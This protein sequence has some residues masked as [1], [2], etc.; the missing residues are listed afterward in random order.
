MSTLTPVNDYFGGTPPLVQKW[1]SSSLSWS[2]KNCSVAVQRTLH[3]ADFT[4]FILSVPFFPVG[5]FGSGVASYFIF[6][7]WLFGIN[8]V[9]TMMTAAFIVIPEVRTGGG[10]IRRA[11]RSKQGRPA[12]SCKA[13][14]LLLLVGRRTCALTQDSQPLP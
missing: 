9:L 3:C 4:P 14:T 1:H 7:R 5:H 12:Q 2:P 10:A 6:L 8:I 13:A 11:I